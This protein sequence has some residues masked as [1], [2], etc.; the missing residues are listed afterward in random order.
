MERPTNTMYPGSL[1][2]LEVGPC[3][4]SRFALGV[5]PHFSCPGPAVTPFFGWTADYYFGPHGSEA[6]LAEYD[7]LIAIWLQ[8]GRKFSAT[9]TGQDSGLTVNGMLVSCLDCAD[10]YHQKDVEPTTEPVSIRLALRPLRSI[11]G[12]IAAEEFGRRP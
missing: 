6:S 3:R 2:D 5:P 11:Y 7:R 1:P 9:L 12:Y 10:P 4:F 8:N